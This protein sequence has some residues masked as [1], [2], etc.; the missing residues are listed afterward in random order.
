MLL[1]AST[2]AAHA[3]YIPD[4]PG[5]IITPSTTTAGSQVSFAGQGCPQGS[6]VTFT[7]NGQVLASGP[8][9]P[10]GTFNVPGTVPAGLADGQYT[11]IATCGD[12]TMS[13]ILTIVSGSSSVIPGTPGTAGTSGTLPQTGSNSLVIARVALA[14]LA[15]GGLIVL[16]TRRRRATA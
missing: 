3:Q 9:N 11:V 8:V 7:L 2:T 15:V 14:L 10:D 13:N 12:V 4:Q 16:G 6:T 1:V 5:F